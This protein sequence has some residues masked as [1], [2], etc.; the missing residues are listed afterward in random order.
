MQGWTVRD[1]T[2]LF[3]RFRPLIHG[4][5]NELGGKS[6]SPQK[7]SEELIGGIKLFVERNSYLMMGGGS[8]AWSTGL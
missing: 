5:Q 3:C 4:G 2:A 6:D 7:F 8:R 1:E